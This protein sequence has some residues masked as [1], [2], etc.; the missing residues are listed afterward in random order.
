[1]GEG[2]TKAE[3]KARRDALQME[4]QVIND[5]APQS[6]RKEYEKAQERLNKKGIVEGEDFTWSDAE[7]DRFLPETLRQS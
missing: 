6:G 2:I 4:Y 7:I 3:I 5:L 1:M